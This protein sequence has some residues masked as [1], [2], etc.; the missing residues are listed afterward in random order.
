MCEQHPSF[1]SR[2][3]HEHAAPEIVEMQRRWPHV[4]TV[5]HEVVARLYDVRIRPS[6]D[7]LP[8]ELSH[9]VR[10]RIVN[11]LVEA[12]V[13]DSPEGLRK[14]VAE[15]MAARIAEY[16]LWSRLT[17]F[18]V[19]HELVTLAAWWG[20]NLPH[21]TF[22][23]LRDIGLH[24]VVNGRVLPVQ[25]VWDELLSAPLV[26]MGHCACRSSG[27]C[28]DLKDQDGNVFTYTSDNQNRQLLER[29]LRRYYRLKDRHGGVVPDTDAKFIDLFERLAAYKRARSTEYRLETLLRRTWPSWEFLPVLEKY[30]QTWVRSLKTNRKAHLLHPELA[31]EMATVLYASRGAVFSSMKCLG[32]PYSICTCPTPETGGGCV[33]TNWYYSGMSNSSLLPN[34][35]GHGRRRNHHGEPAPCNVFPLRAKRECIGC[36]CA[37][38]ARVPR[39]FA[40]VIRQA[41]SSRKDRGL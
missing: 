5:L 33:L 24:Y 36:G 12:I 22:Q 32:Q 8:G 35:N 26:Y 16:V 10:A 14:N 19:V 7:P 18:P 28:R 27:M 21:E 39:S 20:S 2:P 1:S 40:G 37:H 31:H 29:V 25:Q 6:D 9:V 41:D 15:Q 13:R 30:T 38:S 23:D 34:E 3:G 11:G 4:Q 17:S